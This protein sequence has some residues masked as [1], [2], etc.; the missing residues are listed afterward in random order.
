[1][2][3]GS[4]SLLILQ[5]DLQYWNLQS[6]ASDDAEADGFKS[7]NKGSNAIYEGNPRKKSKATTVAKAKSKDKDLIKVTSCNLKHR[8]LVSGLG[9]GIAHNDIHDQPRSEH[10]AIG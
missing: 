3:D 6:E 5:P 2:S 8:I 4:V 1:M 9:G 7:D 10:Y